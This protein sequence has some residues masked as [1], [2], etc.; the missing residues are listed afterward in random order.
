MSTATNGLGNYKSAMLQHAKDHTHHFRKTDVSVL[1][2]ES[3][4]AKRGIKEAIFICA[5][6]PSINVDPGRHSLS[7]HFDSI[8]KGIV[9]KP[10]PPPTHNAGAETIISTAPRRQGRPRREESHTTPKTI[11]TQQEPQQ[12]QQLRPQPQRQSQRLINRQQQHHIP[13]TGHPE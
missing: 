7:S 9:S 8:L 2:S 5:L 6:E 12:N 4:W 10:A 11:T 1:C 3:D 13:P